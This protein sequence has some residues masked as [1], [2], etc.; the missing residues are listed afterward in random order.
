MKTKKQNT[1]HSLTT[2][3]S[4]P[5]IANPKEGILGMTGQAKPSVAKPKAENF[6]LL[7]ALTRTPLV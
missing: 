7:D 4:I 5:I 3:M 6:N 2:L 1:N